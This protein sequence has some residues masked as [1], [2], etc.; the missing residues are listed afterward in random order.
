V[1]KFWVVW[2]P[3]RGDPTQ[4][5]DTLDEA[6]DE[7]QRLANLRPYAYYVLECVGKMERLLPAA[8]WTKANDD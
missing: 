7:A 3:E 2:C 8:E 4:Q 1:K 5:F 6:M